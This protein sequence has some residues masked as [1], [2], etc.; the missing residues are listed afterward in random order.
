MPHQN[1]AGPASPTPA[2]YP[3][4]MGSGFRSGVVATGV[5]VNVAPVVPLS[6]TVR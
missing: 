6:F 4:I 5:P 3:A 2:R 1:N